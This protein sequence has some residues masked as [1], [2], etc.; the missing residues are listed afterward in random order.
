MKSIGPPG[1][2]LLFLGVCVPHPHR[3]PRKALHF[4]GGHHRP[5]GKHDIVRHVQ[6]TEQLG[7][8][9]V[10]MWDGLRVGCVCIELRAHVRARVHKHAS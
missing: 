6:L 4:L 3:P 5:L 1:K 8:R 10:K 9:F 7:C 2:A